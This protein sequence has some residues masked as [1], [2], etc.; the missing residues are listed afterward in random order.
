MTTKNLSKELTNLLRELQRA[1]ALSEDEVKSLHAQVK[2][3]AHG[4]ASR[5]MKKVEKALNVIARI[6]RLG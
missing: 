3:L 4:V 1:G 2:D 6:I 5:N